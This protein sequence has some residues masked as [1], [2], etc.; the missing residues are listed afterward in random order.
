MEI[1]RGKVSRE[2]DT[3]EFAQ[4]LAGYRRVLIDLGTGDGRFV[5]RQA[6][7]QPGAFVIGVDACREN[8]RATSREKCTNALFVIANAGCLP[9]E[10]G[11]L[12]SQLTINFPW[13]SLLA[14]LLQADPAL[15]DGLLAITRPGAS[16]QLRLN[17]GA[18]AEAGWAF[19]Q[20]ARRVQQSLLAAGFAL[21]KPVPLGRDALRACPSTWARRLAA[22]RDPRA[23]A[24]SGLRPDLRPFVENARASISI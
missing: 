16:V 22:G 15:M 20:G 4:H 7:A 6:Q 17:A 1:I 2:M 18:L 19:E 3:H 8:L 14:G 11:G 12:A 13:G 23:M 24:L 5:L 21:D 10:L 9:P